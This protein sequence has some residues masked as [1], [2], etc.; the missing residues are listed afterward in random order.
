MS[1]MTTRDRWD[2]D[3]G[4]KNAA[5]PIEQR[6]TA[7]RDG[8]IVVFHIGMRINALWKIQLW[9]PILLF[10][11][12]MVRELRADPDSGLLGSRTVVGPG[13]RHIGFVQY[14]ESFDALKEYAHDGDRSHVDGWRSYLKRRENG[15]VGIWHETY[16]VA[17]GEY[18]TVYDNVPPH[19]LAASEGTEIVPATGRRES[20]AGRIGNASDADE[21]SG[22]DGTD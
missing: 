21:S 16:R 5:E 9:L 13:I 12:R 20:A 15:A 8:G 3:S 10:G 2:G 18:E 11:P 19:G 17:A 14:W 7:E 4:T 1:V 22:E 6:V